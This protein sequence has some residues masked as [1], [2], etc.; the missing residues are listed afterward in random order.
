MR[1]ALHKVAGA[2]PEPLEAA[3]RG[4]GALQVFKAYGGVRQHFGMAP[5]HCGQ[6]VAQPDPFF[7]QADMDRTLVVQ[8]ALS[9]AVAS[10][11]AGAFYFTDAFS[12]RNLPFGFAEALGQGVA[13]TLIAGSLLGVLS[14]L[15]VA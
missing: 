10:I 8:R 15:A 4:V 13:R 11:P 9:L 1:R 7:G 12:A 14:G 6:A 3:E 5:M 2:D